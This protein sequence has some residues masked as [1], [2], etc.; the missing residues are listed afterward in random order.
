M[1]FIPEE[2]AVYCED[3]KGFTERTVHGY[4]SACAGAAITPAL[5]DRSGLP[6]RIEAVV[7]ILDE[8]ME[9]MTK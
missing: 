5:I 4:C 3:C 9:A 7:Q 6:Q 2:F 8:A 1:T